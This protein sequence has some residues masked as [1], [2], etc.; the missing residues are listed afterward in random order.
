MRIG[1]HIL[2]TLTVFPVFLAAISPCSGQSLPTVKL[3]PETVQAFQ[4][5]VGIQEDLY[6]QGMNGQRPF[7]WID[8]PPRNRSMVETGEIVIEQDAGGEV[9]VPGGIIQNWTGAVFIPGGSLAKTLK[10]LLDY[11]RHRDIYADVVDSR[12]LSRNGDRLTT[13]LRLVKKNVLTVVLDT[14]HEVQ[15]RETG[16]GRASIRSRS[17]RITEVRNAGESDEIQLPSEEDSGFLWR[18]NAYWRLEATN[19]GLYVELSTISLSRDIPIGLAWLMKPF[20][21]E[22]PQESLRSTLSATRRAMLQ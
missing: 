4:G 20:I 8:D 3:G 2:R 19:R 14:E 7:L 5:Y 17:T 10:L 9:A 13:Y 6:Q 18:L 21:R 22:V 11:D 12:L 15:V 1:G 16:A